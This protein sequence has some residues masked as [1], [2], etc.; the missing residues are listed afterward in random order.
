MARDGKSPSFEFRFVDVGPHPD[1]RRTLEKKAVS[2]KWSSIPN[3]LPMKNTA[4]QHTKAVIIGGV[5][6][7]ALRC[8]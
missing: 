8:C 1:A 4:P 7:P 3:S 6:V 5:Q 2:Y